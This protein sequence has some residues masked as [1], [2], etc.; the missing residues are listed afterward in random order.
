MTDSAPYHSLVDA[1]RRVPR[2]LAAFLG[3]CPLWLSAPLPAATVLFSPLDSLDGWTVRCVG[4]GS[5]GIVETPDGGKAAEL[6]ATRGTVFLSR[7]LPLERTRG[8]RVA[9]SCLVE[10]SQIVGGP[11]AASCGKLHLA[12]QTPAGTEH[13]SVHFTGTERARSEGITADVPAD[14]T[15]VLL[16]LGLEAC[17]G[18]IRLDQLLVKNDRRGAL[19]LDLTKVLNADHGQLGLDV[20]PQGVI[21]WDGIPFQIVDGSQQGGHDSLRL[22]GLDHPDW[23]VGT[24]VPI[25][26]GSAASA[27]YI[28]H[29]ALGGQERRDSPAYI[30]TAHFV[31][32]HTF[33]ESIFEGRQIGAV[34]RMQDLENWHVAWKQE[35]PSGPAV[36]FGVTK[37]TI[38]SDTPIESLSCRAYRGASPVV[39]AVT[40][41]EEPPAP[42]SA[43]PEF[44]EMGNPLDIYE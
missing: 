30:W 34:G 21:E 14:A 9:V 42:E 35:S 23:P 8:C 41:V 3:L 31:G 25:R 39:L 38:Y 7:E 36:S 11:Q 20:F 6:S 27:I 33:S 16:N 17:T 43:A 32:D 40:V 12:V 18:R 24:T 28:L 15:R 37:W 26:V 13:F 44:D 29:A 22:K 10:N 1:R 19:P 5:A 4:P 2:V